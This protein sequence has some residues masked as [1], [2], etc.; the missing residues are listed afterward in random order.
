MSP[1]DSLAQ[2]LASNFLSRASSLHGFPYSFLGRPMPQAA[3]HWRDLLRRAA[4]SQRFQEKVWAESFRLLPFASLLG[5]ECKR[6]TN[7]PGL[8]DLV[9]WLQ[10]KCFVS[11]FIL[12]FE[13][14]VGFW[15]VVFHE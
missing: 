13:A 9:I 10:R 14:K 15:R 1:F 2:W 6:P 5:I 7:R 12:I 11:Y 3:T 8:G 4:E